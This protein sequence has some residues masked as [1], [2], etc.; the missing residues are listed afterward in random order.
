MHGMTRPLLACS[1]LAALL[2][3]GVGLLAAHVKAQGRLAQ[4]AAS[5]QNI[6][7][8]RTADGHPDLNGLWN[9]IPVCPPQCPANIIV[10]GPIADP[11]GN[12]TLVLQA[13][14]GRV[15]GDI[16][17]NFER[18][19]GIQRRMTT[20]LPVYK[21]EYW[22]RIQFLD[23]N[24][25]LGEDPG[26]GCASEGIPRMGPPRRIIQTPTLMIFLYQQGAAGGGEN[27]FREIPMDGRP[28]PSEDD[29]IGTY[30]GQSVARWEGDTLAIE[31]VDF[32]ENT[33]LDFAGYFHSD[34]MRVTERLRREGNTIR[35]QATVEDPGVLMKPW[36]MD[37]R[38]LML[39]P[40]PKAIIEESL[41]CSERDQP[42]I[43]T[44][45]RG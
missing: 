23:E 35:Y 33:W 42:H 26:F 16:A 18:D 1:A 11:A 3:G 17:A 41:P 34:K 7:T 12:L 43:V 30:M 36:V 21:P 20:N 14:E 5:G 31:S 40:D 27:T 25:D 29:F 24:G 4:N 13:R 9:V 19:Q 15:E 38:T 28:L 2:A 10:G 32:I 22:D 6:P 39:N 45:E 37:A 8:P 44:K